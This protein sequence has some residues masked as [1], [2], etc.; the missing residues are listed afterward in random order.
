MASVKWR[1]I[2]KVLLQWSLG[3]LDLSFLHKWSAYDHQFAIASV[4][5]R[6]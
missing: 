3:K 1:I 2:C 5:N 6:L 4:G